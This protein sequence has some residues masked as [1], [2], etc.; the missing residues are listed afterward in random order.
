MKFSML[1]QPVGFMKVVL[2][3]FLFFHVIFT[4]ENSADVTF[5]KYMFNI[6][7]SG[8]LW[9]DLFQTCMRLDTCKLYSLIPVRMTLM[10]SQGHRVTGKVELVQSFC[11]ELH[12]ATQIFMMID[13]VREMTVK[14]SC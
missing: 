13:Y 12:E 1:P 14:K 6:V 7:V 8:H 11:C 10:F 4:G 9:T 3:L 5:M 2:I